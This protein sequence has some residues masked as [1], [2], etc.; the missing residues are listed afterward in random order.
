M[1]LLE[2]VETSALIDHLCDAVEVGNTACAELIRF[3]FQ[4]R[5]DRHEF[6]S[7]FEAI[8]A[9]LCPED[10]VEMRKRLVT[11]YKAIE[12][13]DARIASLLQ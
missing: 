4:C 10:P 5:D 9:K 7:R 8:V 13:V 6:R 2:R 1:G 3:E 12:K 11:I